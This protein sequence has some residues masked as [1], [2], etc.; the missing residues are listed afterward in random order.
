MHYY[1]DGY[2]LIFRTLVS[3]ESLQ[4]RRERLIADLSDKIELLKL[5]TTLVFDSQYQST[6]ATRHHYKNMEIYYTDKAETAD[7]YIIKSVK[8]STRKNQLTVIT[9]DLQ[10]AWRVRREGAL[11]M[12]VEEYLDW[13]QRRFRNK[14]H[15]LRES[16]KAP[17]PA[18][19]SVLPK[20]LPEP[21][22]IQK[23]TVTVERKTDIDFYMEQFGGVDNEEV[24]AHDPKKDPHEKPVLSKDNPPMNYES[25]FDRWLREFEK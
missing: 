21:Q 15:Q 25:D 4:N 11:T 23:K 5:D 24:S 20:L 8:N 19:K 14:V 17:P 12:L 1:V 18:E 10:L 7:D 13:L 9:S 3:G 22:K 6:E 2:N 16:L